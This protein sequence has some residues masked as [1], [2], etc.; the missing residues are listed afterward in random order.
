[1]I[2]KNAFLIIVLMAVL[3]GSHLNPSRAS[4]DTPTGTIK[5]IFHHNVSAD[6]FDPSV[7]FSGIANYCVL[8]LYHD[9]LLKPMAGN[10]YAPCLAESWNVSR[11]A[12]VYEFK[13]RKGVK[14][15]NGDE[16]TA[17]DVVFT[18][19]RYKGGAAKIFHD[20]IE[21]LEA[22]NPHLFR[23]TLKKP[24]PDF[25][26]YLLPGASTIAWIVPKKYIEKVGD[27][28]YKRN[29]IGCGP[30]KFVEA[31][32][33]IRFVG[34]AFPGFWRKVPK[35]ARLEI[36]TVPEIATR[37]AMVKKGE[38]DFA[39][40]IDDIFYEKVKTDPTLRILTGPSPTIWTAY[41]A[42]QWDAKS[43]WSDPRVR[44]AASLA[45]DR[46]TVVSIH[47]PGGKPADS[48]GLP[49]DPELIRFPVDPYDPEQA[50]KLLAEAGYPNGFDGG[51]FYPY[52]GPILPMGQTIANYW[53]RVGINLDTIILDSSSWLA[54][55]R[56]GKMKGA[57]IIDPIQPPTISSRLAY[58]FGPQGS[59][60][61]YPDIQSSW[62]QYNQSIDPG[63]RKGLLA[64]IQRQIHDRTMFIPVLQFT[65][66]AAVG[67]RIKGNFFKIEEPFPLWWPCPWEEIELNG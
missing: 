33:G 57:I 48:I 17:E 53:K 66:P 19:R 44:K 47:A 23:I 28:E 22:V 45:I 67:P 59:Y 37:Y 32:P 1:M 16:M 31:K 36:Y 6:W 10:L 5:G 54:H 40:L 9:A 12:R 8:Y 51:K 55:R 50:K 62:D 42:S 35:V 24:F 39:L 3:I 2:K 60:G 27:A 29:P 25:L 18:F 65:V 49:G 11:D 13:L 7:T 43:P 30:Y 34:E 64:K 20:R 21:K 63:T 15:Q 46:K 41:I 14:F 52:G 56:G 61:N 4:A 26:E 58:L 38:V